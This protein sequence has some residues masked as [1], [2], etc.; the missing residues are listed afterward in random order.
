MTE[1]T[2]LEQAR[3]AVAEMTAKSEA[4]LA[5]I[6]KHKAR[7]GRLEGGIQSVLREVRVVP[8]NF[9]ELNPNDFDLVPK[10][11]INYLIDLL[12]DETPRE[13]PLMRPAAISLNLGKD[14]K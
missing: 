7:V 13:M 11:L 12:R 2:T 5:E 1:Q 6:R 3:K 10:P 4:W 9:K 14:K 8:E